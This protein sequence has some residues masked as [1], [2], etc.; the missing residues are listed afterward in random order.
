MRIIDS[1]HSTTN[2]TIRQRAFA[3]ARVMAALKAL[4]EF[5]FAHT[6]ERRTFRNQTL[7]EERD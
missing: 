7:I 4:L 5:T 6:M 1:C 3:G 2:T